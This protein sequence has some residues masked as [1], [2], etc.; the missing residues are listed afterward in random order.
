MKQYSIFEVQKYGTTLEYDT[1]YNLADS[2]FRQASPGG[3]VMYKID[4]ATQTKAA[5]KVR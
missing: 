1:N 5:I 4:P 3:V 2:A